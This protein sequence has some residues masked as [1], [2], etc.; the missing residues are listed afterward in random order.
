MH[1]VAFVE[2]HVSMDAAPLLTVVGLAVRVSVGA[3]GI[4]PVTLTVT[5]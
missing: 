1:A 5:D 3:G 2:D 4:A